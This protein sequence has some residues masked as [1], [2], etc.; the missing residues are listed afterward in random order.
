MEGGG[1]GA[2]GIQAE[3]AGQER[4]EEEVKFRDVAL[5]L[6]GGMK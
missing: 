3:V 4:G 5:T 6:G 1:T 2:F